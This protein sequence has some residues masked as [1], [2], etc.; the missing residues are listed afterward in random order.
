MHARIESVSH[1][2]NNLAY[3]ISLIIY[4]LIWGFGV[5]GFWG[6]GVSFDQIGGETGDFDRHSRWGPQ[7]SAGLS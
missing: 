2:T 7:Q 6:F 3:I 1:L 4:I 5:L